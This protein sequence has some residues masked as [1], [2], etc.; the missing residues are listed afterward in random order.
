[1]GKQTT[2]ANCVKLFTVPNEN[3][4]SQ[5]MDIELGSVSIC[6]NLGELERYCDVL[7]RG[8][9]PPLLNI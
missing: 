4:P 9:N 3:M 1:M 5:T 8:L 6:R 2:A 7:E